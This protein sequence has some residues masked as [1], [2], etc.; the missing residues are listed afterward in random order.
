LIVA[1]PRN[2]EQQLLRNAIRCRRVIRQDRTVESERRS[3]TSDA[4]R[5]QGHSE[6]GQDESAASAAGMAP[7]EPYNDVY[8]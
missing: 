1:R 4:H 2:V 3:T 6:W 8:N 7:H 5:Q